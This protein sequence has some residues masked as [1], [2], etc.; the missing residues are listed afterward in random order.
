MAPAAP[1]TPFVRPRREECVPGALFGPERPAGPCPARPAPRALRSVRLG[2]GLA[3][4][5][6]GQLCLGRGSGEVVKVALCRSLRSA[7]HPRV[8]GRASQDPPSWAEGGVG[9]GTGAELGVGWLARW[10]WLQRHLEVQVW[11]LR[12]SL[13]ARGNVSPRSP[14]TNLLSRAAPWPAEPTARPRSAPQWGQCRKGW[15]TAAKVREP[16]PRVV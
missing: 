9:L 2:S 4:G 6:G 1:G 13:T 15:E 7:G 16:A 12:S 3:L 8:W 14:P 10:V 11:G 5:L